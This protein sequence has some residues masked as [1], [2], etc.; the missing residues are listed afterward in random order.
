MLWY[1]ISYDIIC[2]LYFGMLEKVRWARI[3]SVGF[4]L[5]GRNKKTYIYKIN[6]R[7]FPM[8]PMQI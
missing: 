7:E 1:N 8:S 6:N 3:T 2:A 4:F 5:W